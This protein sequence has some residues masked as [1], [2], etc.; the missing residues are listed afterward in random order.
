M[1]HT[2]TAVKH[3]DATTKGTFQYIR[4]VTFKQVLI[5]VAFVTFVMKLSAH[6]T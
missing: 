5:V 4:Y 3:P 6:M 1:I 2:F